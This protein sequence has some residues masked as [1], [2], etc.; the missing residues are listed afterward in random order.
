MKAKLLNLPVS[1]DQL[2]QLEHLFS[3]FL[4]YSVF[5]NDTVDRIN[6]GDFGFLILQ[7]IVMK[8]SKDEGSGLHSWCVQ[9]PLFVPVD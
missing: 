7:K 6:F 3:S 9:E 8:S 1:I 2:D 5:S 4:F